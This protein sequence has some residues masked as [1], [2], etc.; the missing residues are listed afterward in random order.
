MANVTLSAAPK[1][2]QIL[3]FCSSGIS[4]ASAT[5]SNN[6]KK[7]Y[8]SIIYIHTHTEKLTM[9]TNIDENKET[10]PEKAFEKPD[11]LLQLH[12]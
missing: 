7:H 12:Y 11:T 2:L 3:A 8:I 9:V 4:S 5:T 6:W 10:R 1:H